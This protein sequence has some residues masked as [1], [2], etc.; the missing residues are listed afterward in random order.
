MKRFRAFISR[1]L[2]ESARLDVVLPNRS[3]SFNFQTSLPEK[4]DK[5]RGEVGN[6][7]RE[8]D[9]DTRALIARHRKAWRPRSVINN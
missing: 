1:D 2:I 9:I 4:S 6:D 5:P 8:L 7:S 3:P